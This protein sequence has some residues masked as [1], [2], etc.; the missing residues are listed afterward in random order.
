V[1]VLITGASGFIG[2]HL[3]RRLAPNHDVCGVIFRS[4]RKLPFPAVRLDLTDERSTA[5]AI[6]EFSP[7]VIV[8]AAAISRVVECEDRPD[9]AYAVNVTATSRLLL[10][11]ERLHAKFIYLSSDQVFSGRKGAR[12][13]SDPPDPMNRYGQMKLEAESLILRSA[14]RNLVI[15]SNSVVGQSQ[16]WGESFSDMILTKLRRSEPVVLFEDQYRSPIHIRSL[17]D[18]LEAACVKDLN[19]L[20]HAGGLERL[21]RLDTGY[22]LARAYGLSPD[23][24]QPGTYL[25]H[26][27]AAIFTADTSYD[28]SRLRQM[29]PALR[30]KRIDEEF[31]VDAQSSES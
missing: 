23:A 27:R 8:H 3:G 12:R 15:R 30:L 5:E 9:A 29:I 1:R 14:A 31:V 25:S 19:G 17:V 28:T 13:E 20:L 11:A 26:P 21:S 18:V 4:L 7:Q 10:W 16:G 24:I 6:R 22:A 2:S